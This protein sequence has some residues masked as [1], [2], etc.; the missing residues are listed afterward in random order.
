MSLRHVETVVTYLETTAPPRIYPPMPVGAKLALMKAEAIPLHFYR[1]LYEQVGSNWLWYER[2]MLDD[3][4]LSKRLHREGVEVFVLYANGCPAG[5]FELDFRDPQRVNLV[6]F[7]LLPEW[8][9]RKI[10]PWLL[11]C[12]LSEAFARAPQRV[13]V[14]TC[15]LD[16]PAALALYQRLGFTPQAQEQRRLT[17]PPD[18]PIPDHIAAR[19][20][21]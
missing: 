12:A 19:I 6:Y 4:A 20:A 3:A 10:G 11:G 18:V 9:G 2:L 21:P 17:V 8:T 15:T 16:H 14:N 5:Y 7:G 13:T 1:Y